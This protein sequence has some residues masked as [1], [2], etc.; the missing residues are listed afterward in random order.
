M[1]HRESVVGGTCSFRKAMPPRSVSILKLVWEVVL[2]H[3]FRNS[4]EVLKPLVGNC[5]IS[6][7]RA[8]AR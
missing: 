1:P 4:E 8:G 3:N 2:L 7:C 5:A 6:L